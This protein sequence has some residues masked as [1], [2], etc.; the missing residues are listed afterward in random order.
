MAVCRDCEQEMTDPHGSS[1][2]YT[3]L[4]FANGEIRVR[5]GYS[6]RRGRGDGWAR[7]VHHRC[8]DCGVMPGGVHH[9]GCDVERCP[10]CGRQLISCGCPDEDS[11]IP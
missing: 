9:F 11:P 10:R 7:N 3:R 4:R 2:T 5:V 6:T 1:C 8:H